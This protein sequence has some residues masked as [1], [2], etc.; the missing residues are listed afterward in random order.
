MPENRSHKYNNPPIKEA[1]FDLQIR[2]NSSFNENLFK[3]FLKQIGDYTSH[4]VMRNIDIDTHTNT[5]TSQIVGY[6]CISKD[7]KQI[8]QFKKYGFSFSRLQ[9]Y[10]GWEKNCRE[11]LRL[12]NIYCEV[13]RPTAITRVATRFINQFHIPHVFAKPAEYFNTYIQY[14][15]S[16][17]SVWG[18]MSY[19]LLLTH[20]SSIKSHIM[21]NNNINQNDQSVN[22]VFDI[23]VFSERLNLLQKDTSNVENIF[24]QMR[25]VK[26]EI[27]E[28]GITD[29]TRSL[30]Q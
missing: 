4:G 6:R 30:I 11:A 28:K 29:K 9:I 10:D 2:S 26:N 24:N 5:Q 16:I 7:E 22:V 8:V 3:E 23:D 27:F 15:D 25:K 20:S 18:Q 14:D 12:W 19:R 21:F 13:M 1:V 17:S